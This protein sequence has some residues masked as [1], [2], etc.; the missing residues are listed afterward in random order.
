MQKIAKH[1]EI[2]SKIIFLII[3]LIYENKKHF[4][5]FCI[6]KYNQVESAN[7]II[8]FFRVGDI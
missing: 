5:Y 8:L 3:Y 6:A 1:K 7:I 2:I 4:I